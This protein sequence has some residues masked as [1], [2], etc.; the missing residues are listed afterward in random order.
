MVLDK[1]SWMNTAGSPFPWTWALDRASI[2]AEA[3]GSGRGIDID[4]LGSMAAAA[5]DEGKTRRKHCA[6]VG[7]WEKV[8]LAAP[9][10][11]WVGESSWPCAPE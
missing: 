9:V 10:V 5:E 6:Q 2:A 8:W 11:R 3:A 7:R 1:V 4:N